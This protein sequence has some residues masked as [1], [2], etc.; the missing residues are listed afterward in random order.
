MSYLQLYKQA[1]V[2]IKPILQSIGGYVKRNPGK[3]L[4]TSLFLGNLLSDDVRDLSRAAVKRI[5]Q[6]FARGIGQS[7][8]TSIQPTQ[9]AIQKSIKS[10]TST[11]RNQ[12]GKLKEAAQEIAEPISLVMDKTF[13]SMGKSIQKHLIPSLA[14]LGVAGTSGFLAD[15]VTPYITKKR[16]LRFLINMMAASGT[17]VLTYIALKKYMQKQNE[18]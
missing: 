8:A 12:S 17:G 16:K 13:S 10:T 6:P 7:T 11:L 14:A 5:A 2:P 4:S 9:K 3:T 1:G 15:Y 18:K